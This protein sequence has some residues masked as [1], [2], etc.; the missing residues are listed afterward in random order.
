MFF[1]FAFPHD[2]VNSKGGQQIFLVPTPINNL[3]GLNTVLFY[4]SISQTQIIRPY[5]NNLGAERKLPSFE[6]NV[7]VP[8]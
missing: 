2:I 7:A 8:G 4:S 5:L 6:L 1:F 3:Q